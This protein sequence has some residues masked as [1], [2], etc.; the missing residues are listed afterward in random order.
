MKE[1]TYI[2][3]NKY[4]DVNSHRNKDNDYS[5]LFSWSLNVALQKLKNI[6][7]RPKFN[8][9]IRGSNMVGSI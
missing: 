2:E 6:I 4:N 1:K 8:N 9:S 3:K 7:Q 5:L